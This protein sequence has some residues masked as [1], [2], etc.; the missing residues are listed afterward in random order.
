[1]RRNE[2]CPWNRANPEQTA[3]RGGG[4]LE[5]EPETRYKAED[6]DRSVLLYERNLPRGPKHSSSETSKQPRDPTIFDRP[7]QGARL[8][9]TSGG[10]P[11]GLAAVEKS[12]RKQTAETKAWARRG[13]PPARKNENTDGKNQADGRNLARRQTTARRKFSV[14]YEEH[15]EEHSSRI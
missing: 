9:R 13:N 15:I 6:R 7:Y 5:Q 8:L 2:V 4:D 14:C 11:R 10:K 3:W 12:S 1:M